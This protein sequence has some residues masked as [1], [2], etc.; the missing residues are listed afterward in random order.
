[1]YALGC[2]GVCCCCIYCSEEV[3]VALVRTVF[4]EYRFV[5][6][7]PVEDAVESVVCPVTLSVPL[8]TK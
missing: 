8:D 3:E 2:C 1:M 4:V 7:S 6:V 5:A